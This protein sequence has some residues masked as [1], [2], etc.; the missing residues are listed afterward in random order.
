MRDT[1][2]QF[3]SRKGACPQSKSSCVTL[4]SNSYPA[5]VRVPNQSLPQE[6]VS[7]IK[8]LQFLSRKSACPQSKSPQ[9]KS[10]IQVHSCN[11][12]CVSP[13]HA[14]NPCNKRKRNCKRSHFQSIIS[15]NSAV[16]RKRAEFLRFG[17]RAPRPM[18]CVTC[19]ISQASNHRRK[20]RKVGGA[21]L[22]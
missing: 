18:Y 3:L 15:A 7:P 5:K 22:C 4:F 9:S 20:V 12:R 2:L 8:V 1:I 11:K 16:G 17:R 14:T 21:C 6:C 13:I 19:S 10:P